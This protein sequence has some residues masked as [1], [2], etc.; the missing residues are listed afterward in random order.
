M[1]SRRTGESFF[2]SLFVFAACCSSFW[3][4]KH[5]SRATIPKAGERPC[6]Y[7]NQCRQDLRLTLLTAL[8][9]AQESIHLTVFG[10]SDPAVVDALENKI[11]SGVDTKV[12]YD[13][14]GGSLRL[15]KPHHRNSFTAIRKSG[16][17]H[18]KILVIDRDLV[19]L[20]SANMTSASLRMHD[21]LI[22]GL[23]SGKVAEFLMNQTPFSSGYLK[24]SVGGQSVEIWLLPDPRGHALS[25]LRHHLRSAKKTIHIALFTLTHPLL[26]DDI[27][28]AKRRGVAVTLVIDAHSGLGASS[29]AIEKLRK[30]DITILFSQGLQLLHH[31]FVLIDKQTLISGSANWTKAA[32]LKNSDCLLILH[33][34]SPDQKRYIGRLW[35]R[36]V[37]EGRNV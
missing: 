1:Q 13:P 37:T 2:V 8:K 6:F 15:S 23:R 12:Y 32:F 19:M 7:S 18:Q 16:L 27:L 33:Q 10:L 4:I 36:I 22:V 35:R 20:G 11:D 31:K 21:N 24:T 5:S 9:T 28:A 17:M 3:L 29:K 14:G 25:D 30:G 34:L 26:L